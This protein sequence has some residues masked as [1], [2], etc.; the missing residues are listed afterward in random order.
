LQRFPH[1]IA[2][3]ED[4]TFQDACQSFLDRLDGEQARLTTLESALTVAVAGPVT[5]FL[6]LEVFAHRL[7][8]AAAVFDL[9][10]L[11][12]DSK[13]LELAAADAVMRH[14]PINDPHVGRAIRSLKAQLTHV[15]VGLPAA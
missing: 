12:N 11:R 6:D 14:A 7:R 15:N 13:A 5:A 8:R 1:S 10:E 2:A 4:A 3:P 9:P